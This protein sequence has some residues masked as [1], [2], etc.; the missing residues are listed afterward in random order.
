MAHQISLPSQLPWL[1]NAACFAPLPNNFDF[2]ARC[3]SSRTRHR[4]NVVAEKHNLASVAQT[5]ICQY[6]RHSNSALNVGPPLMAYYSYGDEEIEEMVIASEEYILWVGPLPTFVRSIVKKERFRRRNEEQAA[7][8]LRKK[9][10]RKSAPMEH[11]W[12]PDP[13]IVHAK[14]PISQVY[15]QSV[16]ADI[17]SDIHFWTEGKQDLFLSHRHRLIT[18]E[19]TLGDKSDPEEVTVMDFGEMHR[20]WG[21]DGLTCITAMGYMQALQ[22]LLTAVKK[23]VDAP[24]HPAAHELESHI[25]YICSLPHFE[26]SYPYWYSWERETRN[27]I[28]SLGMSFNL[29]EWQ[30]SLC[31]PTCQTPVLPSTPS[32]LVPTPVGKLGESLEKHRRKSHRSKF[33]TLERQIHPEFTIEQSP[34]VPKESVTSGT[35]VGISGCCSQA[36]ARVDGGLL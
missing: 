20:I 18:K 15:L 32:T 35:I 8:E 31:V 10:D 34:S 11:Y 16:C 19:L 13:T 21:T 28:L 3:L 12:V 1:P 26:E 25:K 14:S 24:A 17:V 33:R 5:R 27:K 2:D 23:L 36:S 7:K 22:N 6:D 29:Q 9:K 30:I 4:L